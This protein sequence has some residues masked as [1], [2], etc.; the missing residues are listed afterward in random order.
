MIYNAKS[1]G[2]GTFQYDSATDARRFV[3]A[4]RWGCKYGGTPSYW[5]YMV[6]DPATWTAS[7]PREDYCAI[8]SGSVELLSGDPT[9]GHNYPTLDAYVLKYGPLQ[10]P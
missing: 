7:A 5:L 10:N 6:R 4:S 8:Y 1:P 2:V 3:Y 9:G